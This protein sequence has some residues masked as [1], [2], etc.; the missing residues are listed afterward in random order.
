MWSR[1]LSAR[2]T[3]SFTQSDTHSFTH[4]LTNFCPKVTVNVSNKITSWLNTKIKHKVLLLCIWCIII[5][6]CWS[7]GFYDRHMRSWESCKLTFSSSVKTLE[8]WI[9]DIRL[10][11]T[12]KLNDNKT[13]IL[14]LTSPHCVKSLKTPA[15]Q[16]GVSS[17]TPNGSKKS[18]G[19]FWPM[20]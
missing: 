10:W 14:Y 6:S 4:L 18:R 20:Y 15:L 7:F 1:E 8:H 2:L 17:I 11:M 9:A 16:M 12:Q 19:Y 3:K 13:N 5:F